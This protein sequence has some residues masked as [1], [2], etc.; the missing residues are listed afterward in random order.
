MNGL[1]LYRQYL[2]NIR[3]C[4]LNLELDSLESK[5]Y[6]DILSR[7]NEIE[8][9]SYIDVILKNAGLDLSFISDNRFLETPVVLKSK[10]SEVFTTDDIEDD[11]MQD[12]VSDYLGSFV[13]YEDT[14]MDKIDSILGESGIPDISS[15]Y[16][17]GSSEGIMGV[18]ELLESH[19][20]T[21]GALFNGL[22]SITKSIEEN[23]KE[24]IE[25]DFSEDDFEGLDDGEIEELEENKIEVRENIEEEKEDLEDI[26][27]IEFDENEEEYQIESTVEQV[28]EDID[29]YLV[30]E[31]EPQTKTEDL[32]NEEVDD[33]IDNDEIDCNT[34]ENKKSKVFDTSFLDDD[35]VEEERDD[36]EK[37]NETEDIESDVENDSVDEDSISDKDF[38]MF[39]DEV[40]NTENIEDL[41]EELE[42]DN[43][44]DLD[45]FDSDAL[46]NE[47]SSMYSLNEEED[48]EPTDG[49]L[50]REA[51]DYFLNGGKR[52]NRNESKENLKELYKSKE[53]MVN[54]P[55]FSNADDNFAKFILAIGDGALNLPN[56][57][58]D[59]FKKIKGGSKKMYDNMVVEDDN[60]EE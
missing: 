38:S 16:F 27:D 1:M 50:F 10:I 46:N 14:V 5:K 41:D 3:S 4:I 43:F 6:L 8:D 19:K 25:E 39:L 58:A 24:D 32:E 36:I 55:N 26:D 54:D 52:I 51:T 12:A 60:D 53:R 23:K 31:T 33:S 48:T 37:T 29:F 49:S 17:P 30:D 18:E 42:E 22:S 2:E 34:F 9:M 21:L 57:T 13:A 45:E 56:I 47:V 15:E 40:E 44:E 20:D 59:L 28:E 35:D 7:M 11:E